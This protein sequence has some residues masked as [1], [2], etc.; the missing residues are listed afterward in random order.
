MYLGHIIVIIDSGFFQN[1]HFERE[2]ATPIQRTN[3]V[4]RIEFAKL[5]ITPR[6]TLYDGQKTCPQRVRY[7]ETTL[8]IRIF[9]H[10]IIER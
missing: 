7:S 1:G 10:C 5:V 3:F 4:I 2:R 6:T 9:F 8:Y